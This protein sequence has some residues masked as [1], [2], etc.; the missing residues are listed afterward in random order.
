MK[1]L[2]LSFLRA[3]KIPR[4]DSVKG[5]FGHLYGDDRILHPFQCGS[6]VAVIP[7]PVFSR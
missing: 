3:K 1:S 7:V 2:R 5:T 6:C 4:R